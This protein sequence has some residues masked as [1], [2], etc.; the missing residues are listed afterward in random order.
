MKIKSLF[1]P[2]DINKYVKEFE[3]LTEKDY[4]FFEGENNILI[5]SIHGF[6]HIR[7]D[8]IK[9][10]DGGTILFSFLLS[11]ITKSNF[12]CVFK[13]NLKDNNY[14]DDTDVKKFLLN[15]RKNYKFLLDIHG[16][17]AYRVPDIE[18]GTM[19][20]KT[21]NINKVE[22]IINIFNLYNFIVVENETFAGIGEDDFAETMIN[23]S[24]NKLNIESI[25]LEI[26]SSFIHVEQNLTFWH[27]YYQLLNC[28]G[29][30]IK[31]LNDE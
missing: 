12:I 4:Y 23:F 1:T 28:I 10:K 17:H 9:N 30:I 11:K 25:Q 22:Q 18:I 27:R 3:T 26:N 13:D 7:K 8:K 15:Q 19:Y 16:S 20:N 5:S 2:N 21:I 14:Y 31:R 29:Q 24:K 6:N